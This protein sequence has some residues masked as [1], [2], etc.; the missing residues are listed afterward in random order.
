[1][2]SLL[3]LQVGITEFGHASPMNKPRLTI[4][5]QMKSKDK[6]NEKTRWKVGQM[7]LACSVMLC[8]VGCGAVYKLTGHD[9]MK[10]DKQTGL[11]PS[12]KLKVG[13][14]KL[15]VV[16]HPAPVGFGFRAGL[17]SSDPD[18]V[19]IAY[20]PN[21][22]FL[23]APYVKGIKPG[24]CRV[25]YI[26]QFT[27]MGIVENGKLTPSQKQQA[28][29]DRCRVKG[30]GTVENLPPPIVVSFDVIVVEDPESNTL[31][32]PGRSHEMKGGAK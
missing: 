20:R 1:V 11:L 22:T 21:D 7:W 29:E 8:L 18:I 17:I 23:K 10:A 30:D 26:N 19:T 13:D 25:H 32:V 31:P 16:H 15:A 14:E 12:V 4:D 6:R 27:C 24:T 2:S 3:L 5:H 9:R 28:I